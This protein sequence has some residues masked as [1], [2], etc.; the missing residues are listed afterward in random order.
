MLFFKPITKPKVIQ[1]AQEEIQSA[2]KSIKEG[3]NPSLFKRLF[4]KWKKIKEK[5]N[6]E[7]LKQDISEVDEISAI[8]NTIEK[9]RHALMKFDLETAKKSYIDA[10]KIYNGLK[11]EQQVKVYRDI[12][13]LYLDRKS[14][15]ETKI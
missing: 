2:I 3:Q 7:N 5:P 8:Q 12:K 13:E 1:D 11:P 10:I 9:T 6:E 4:G 14:I 15:E